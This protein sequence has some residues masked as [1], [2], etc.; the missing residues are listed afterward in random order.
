MENFIDYSKLSVGQLLCKKSIEIN[1]NLVKNYL[2]STQDSSGMISDLDG[3]KYVP[4]MAIAAF[5]LQIV[6]DYL[7]IPHGTLHV[8]QELVIES[9]LIIG[10]LIDYEASIATNSVRNNWRFV[11]IEIISKTTKKDIVM[12][13]KST[14]TMPVITPDH[15][16]INHD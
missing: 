14:I 9:P 3:N 6:I 15:Q 2:E 7:K 1:S 10:E 11:T 12:T 4:P 5:G 16:G 8:G 13:T